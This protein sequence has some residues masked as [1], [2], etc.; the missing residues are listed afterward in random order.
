VISGF[1][2]LLSSIV[3]VA[4]LLVVPVSEISANGVVRPVWEERVGSSTLVMLTSPFPPTVGSLHVAVRLDPIDRSNAATH[5]ETS[6]LL[7]ISPGQEL[8][9]AHLEPVVENLKL[10]QGVFDQYHANIFLDRPG[11]WIFTFELVV[12]DKTYRLSQS[13]MVVEAQI[14]KIPLL[15]IAVV[16]LVFTL[17]YLAWWIRSRK[18]SGFTSD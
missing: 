10:Y 7:T 13:L 15:T 3:Y 6:I 11:E 17:G 12:N 9:L 8:L 2:F 14:P 18:Q 5:A 1:W 16:V 4:F